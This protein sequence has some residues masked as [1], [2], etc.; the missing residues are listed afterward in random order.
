MTI[1]LRMNTWKLFH[2]MTRQVK[3]KTNKKQESIIFSFIYKENCYFAPY[4]V[5]FFA[6]LESTGTEMRKKIQFIH[7]KQQPSHPITHLYRLIY[8]HTLIIFLILRF[9]REKRL[10]TLP[11]STL[12]KIL[13]KFN[14]FL[15]FFCILPFFAFD[16][17]IEM[18]QTN[19]RHNTWNEQHHI[20]KIFFY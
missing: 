3:L 4:I 14:I 20:C 6:I 13:N 9:A 18:N 8:V 16:I 2:L 12:M 7:F 19:T 11:R 1:V 5:N 15:I 17:F 10:T